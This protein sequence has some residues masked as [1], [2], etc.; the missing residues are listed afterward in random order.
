MGFGYS[1]SS[2]LQYLYTMVLESKQWIKP[3]AIQLVPVIGAVSQ[4]AGAV[5]HKVT[6]GVTCV[7]PYLLCLLFLMLG[8]E[9]H[10]I[11]KEVSLTISRI[12]LACWVLAFIIT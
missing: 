2:L 1:V 10:Q 5:C 3:A 4:V 6:H 8:I 9:W 7:T 12:L 11:Q